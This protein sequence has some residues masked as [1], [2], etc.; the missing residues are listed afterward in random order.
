LA[1][2]VPRLPD[3][4]FTNASGRVEINAANLNWGKTRIR[5]EGL[6]S[7]NAD[8]FSGGD[9][10]VIDVPHINL[11]LNTKAKV[12]D[13]KD[14]TPDQ[15]ARFGGFIQIYSG[16]W[17]NNYAEVSGTGTNAVTN[18]VE[19]RFELLAI[20]GSDLHSREPVV[21]HELRLRSTGDANGTLIFRENLV[22]TNE[23]EISA[24]NVTFA[25]NSRLFLGKGV[26]FAFTNV[27]NVS[28]FTNLGHIQI[29]ELANLSRNENEGFD[30]F[31]N[32]GELIAFGTVI[33]AKYFE[34]TGDIISSNYYASRLGSSNLLFNSDCYG[35]PPSI[36]VAGM[37]EG[38][39]VLN[40]D[41]AKIDGGQFTTLGDM[42]FS[43][44][45]F[46]FNN[47]RAS[48]GGRLTLDVR[49]VLT[50]DAQVGANRW[51]VNNGFEMTAVRPAGDLLGTE[52]RSSAA[53]LAIVDHIWSA[54][55]R[56][57][58]VAGFTDN[59][60]IGRL[61][62]EGEDSSLFQFIQTQP[63]SAMYV[64]VLEIDGVQAASIRD[65]TNH[66]KLQMNVYYGNVESTNG[67][68]TA[69]RLNRI[70]GTNAPFNF[71]WVSNW[72]GP[73]SGVDVPLTENGPVQRFN[74][75]LRE[76]ANI[77]SDGDGIPN[78]YDPFPFPPEFFGITGFAFS[79]ELKT[80]QFGVM[81]TEGGNYIVEYTT[82]LR[83]EAWTPLKQITQPNPAGG[84]LSITDQ[85]KTG[86]PQRYYRVRKSP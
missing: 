27:A 65:F 43:G 12:L 48:V 61:H 16:I 24:P 9:D 60:A 73:Y 4:G 69:E 84:V 81:T 76:S 83:S 5:G 19:T 44:N 32:R 36:L 40:A 58:T 3:V 28:T 45:V 72:A 30:K 66:V 78:R 26:Q 47:H 13:L 86:S 53:R 63:G 14:M 18:T 77:D 68:F 23:L 85:V 6:V 25:E 80:L 70:L 29:N 56:G 22:V 75:A 37:T 38:D 50:D 59:A 8:N 34:N 64:D 79:S 33:T 39:I 7:I 52:I 62:I 31:V 41:Q 15:V 71:Y 67:V 10:I 55:D 21:A 74:R 49:G 20:R 35:R 2:R 82:D 57:P 1:N 46:K 11:D 17:T 54:E 42:R 51:S